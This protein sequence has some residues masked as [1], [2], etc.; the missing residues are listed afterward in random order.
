LNREKQLSFMLTKTNRVIKYL[1]KKLKSLKKT[2]ILE[3]LYFYVRN[4]E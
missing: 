1:T 2:V 3:T 4:I